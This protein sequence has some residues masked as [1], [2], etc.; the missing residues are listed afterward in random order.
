MS[1]DSVL[2]ACAGVSAKGKRY[3]G[4][5]VCISAKGL[6]ARKGNNMTFY[7]SLSKRLQSLG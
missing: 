6:S 7:P 2:S 4:V 3:S 1:T 5:N